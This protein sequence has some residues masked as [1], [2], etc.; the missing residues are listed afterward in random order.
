M[1]QL[2]DRLF[3]IW[4]RKKVKVE[5]EL[6]LK[7]GITFQCADVDTPVLSTK[8]LAQTGHEV[9]YRKDCGDILDLKTGK[10][11]KF[12]LRGGVYY[13]ELKIRPLVMPKTDPSFVRPGN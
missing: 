2:Q 1:L 8:L 3:Q 4:V 5:T 12:V 13:I 6:G 9:T 7:C 10:R 11:T